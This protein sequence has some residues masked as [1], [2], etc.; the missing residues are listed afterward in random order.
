MLAVSAVLKVLRQR[1]DFHE[2]GDGH[3]HGKVYR[4]A[5]GVTCRPNMRKPKMSY[6]ALYQLGDELEG[7]HI[8]TRREFIIMVKTELRLPV[9]LPKPE[10]M[11]EEL[12]TGSPVGAGP[13]PPPERPPQRAHEEEDVSPP[14]RPK[15]EP[16]MEAVAEKHA[17]QKLSATARAV[18]SYEIVQISLYEVRVKGVDD[19]ISVI[20]QKASREEAIE[21]LTEFLMESG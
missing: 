17:E 2:T 10:I 12:I 7:K 11:P 13:V 16:I 4:N 19:S 3:R 5:E 6:A 15:A 9:A 21:L 18:A 8:V 20:G 14:K 1:L